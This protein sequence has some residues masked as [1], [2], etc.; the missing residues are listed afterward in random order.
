MI[1]QARNNIVLAEL[2]RNSKSASEDLKSFARL[3]NVPITNQLKNGD[4]SD[5]M[6][7][8]DNAKIVVDLAGNIETGNKIIEELR[9]K[10]R[11]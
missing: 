7:L 8:N 2:C 9:G 5:T 10:T 1:S 4:L 11:R 3:L 6:I